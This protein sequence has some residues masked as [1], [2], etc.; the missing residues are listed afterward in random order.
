M[1]AMIGRETA[2]LLVIALALAI[3]VCGSTAALAQGSA[4]PDAVVQVTPQGAL[5]FCAAPSCA[6][7]VCRIFFHIDLA[8]ATHYYCACDNNGSPYMPTETQ[9]VVEV[10]IPT[11]G[12]TKLVCIRAICV[13]D[14]NP[15]AP[16]GTMLF[17]CVCP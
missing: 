14:C 12:N 7:D 2:C 8:G 6:P 15:T 5:L 1:R 17:F 13:N 11:S 4:C 16:P 10:V 9:C 3:F